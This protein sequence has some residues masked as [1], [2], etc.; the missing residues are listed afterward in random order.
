MNYHQATT[1]AIAN[2]SA[3]NYPGASDPRSRNGT[4]FPEHKPRFKI[5]FTPG[6]TV[7]TIGSC[8]AR[9]IEE[10]LFERS[11]FFPTRTFSVSKEEWSSRPNGLL[12]EYNAGTISQRILFALDGKEFPE[13]TIVPSGEGYADLLL[14]PGGDVTH[15]RALGR[16]K[17]IDDVY[18]HL[19]KSDLVII[20]L[21]LVEAWYDEE[22]GLFLNR[23]PPHAV[24]EQYGNRFTLRQLDVRECVRLLEPALDALSSRAIK[25]I[26]TV[27]PVPLHT[28]FA[29]SDCVVANE[30]SKA[31][32]R[33]CAQSLANRPE[34]DYFPSYE[35]VRSG[36]LS[37]YLEDQIHVR[38]ELVREITSYMV[39][40]YERD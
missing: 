32:L 31:V 28:T 27:S 11:V 8:F 35:I 20:T 29:D 17:E 3:R 37:G 40:V 15:E 10:A 16:R 39:A 19:S 38:N 24:G 6:Q 13:S 2:K 5:K 34:V 33:V 9:S 25:T 30:Y 23:T 7:F 12:N 26:L 18:R 4:I 1:Q 14:L 36:G 21:G 22:T